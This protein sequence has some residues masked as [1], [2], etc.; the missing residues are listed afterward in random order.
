MNKKVYV[1]F[2]GRRDGSC[3]TTNEFEQ[4]IWKIVTTKAKAIELILSETGLTPDEDGCAQFNEE[5]HPHNGHEDTDYEYYKYEEHD[6]E[7]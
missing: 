3:G 7:D 1:I 4:E 5:P 2:N 6:L